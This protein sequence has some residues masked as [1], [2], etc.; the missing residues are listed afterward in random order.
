[1]L[2]FTVR[3]VWLVVAVV[4]VAVTVGACGVRPT[5]GAG[6]P[7]ILAA[8][9]PESAPPLPVTTVP[10]ETPAPVAEPAPGPG[11]SGAAIDPAGLEEAARDVEPNTT[12]GAVVFD[13]VTGGFPVSLNGDRQFRSASLVKLMIAIDVLDR[14]AT[15]EERTRVARMLSVSDDRIASAFWSA[16]APGLVTRVVRL[17]GLQSTE[18]PEMAGRWGEVKLT[19]NDVVRVYQYLLND[20]PPADHTLVMDALAQAPQYAAD[21]FDQYFGIPDGLNTQW[22][23][24]QGWGNNDSTMALHSTGVIGLRSRYVVVLLT[25]HPLG[26]GW[27][28]SASSVTA[29]ARAL[30]GRLEGV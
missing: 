12:L 28:T 25:E 21:D 24:K 23:I 17:A 7:V 13:R 26:S 20:L 18:A 30:D 4:G 19:A 16:G 3:R 15:E 29:A 6:D 1:M 27:R 10:A 9:A 8:P 14:G 5:A 11:G 2:T 22:A